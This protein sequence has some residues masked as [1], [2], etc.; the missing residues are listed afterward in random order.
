MYRY[1]IELLAVKP[2]AVV[3]ASMAIVY[4]LHVGHSAEFEHC[5]LCTPSR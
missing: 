3:S 1:G 2:E 5:S 4:M